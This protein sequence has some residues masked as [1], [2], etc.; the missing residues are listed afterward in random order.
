MHYYDGE[1]NEVGGFLFKVTFYTNGRPQKQP[2]GSAKALC[3]PCKI[4]ASVH[5]KQYKMKV[6][7]HT[8][9]PCSVQRK[10]YI[11]PHSTKTSGRQTA[12]V[13]SS[14]E[15]IIYKLAMQNNVQVPMS[16][17]LLIH[18]AGHNTHLVIRNA[19]T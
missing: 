10:I 17:L 19:N 15:V 16:L 4:P 2:L 3:L 13:H 1:A 14:A 12:L 9:L 5:D 6:T 8:N 18:V 7:R 11:A